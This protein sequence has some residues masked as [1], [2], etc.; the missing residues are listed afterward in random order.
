MRASVTPASIRAWRVARLL[1]NAQAARVAFRRAP[2]SSKYRPCS[3]HG[4][5]L[6]GMV[7]WFSGF[8][9]SSHSPAIALSRSSS[10]SSCPSGTCAFASRKSANFSFRVSMLHGRLLMISCQSLSVFTFRRV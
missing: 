6:G 4:M 3:T 8:V 1:A 5:T 9:A 2:G 7:A 10:A